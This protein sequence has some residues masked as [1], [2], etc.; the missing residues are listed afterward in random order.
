MPVAGIGRLLEC[1]YSAESSFCENAESAASNTW[2]NKIAFDGYTLSTN[3]D[4]IRDGSHVSRMNDEG[5]SHIGPRDAA[6]EFTTPLPGHFT[7]T[8]G[9]LTATWVHDLL[10]DA[11]GGGKTDFA[12][13]TVSA[14]SSASSIT[15]T[16]TSNLA[17]GHI[18][19]IGA[20]G[21]GRCDGQ[22]GVVNSAA[23][24][25][26][27]L[28]A[29]PGTPNAADVIYGT[30]LVYP[31]ESTAHTLGTKRFMAGWTSSPTTGQQYHLMGGQL[32]TL[33]FSFP[34][35]TPSPPTVSFGYRFAYYQR[36]A[37]TI[38]HTSL[39]R[40]NNYYAPCMGGS[41]FLADF[42]TATRT[43]VQPASIDLTIDL[44]LEPI[45]GPGGAGIYQQIIGWV[46]TASKPTVTMVLP[47]ATTYE[48]LFDTANA[49]Y[50]YKH[51]LFTGNV[52]DGR[53]VGFY[54]P[55]CMLVGN[56]PSQPTL[57]NGQTYVTVQFVGVESTTTTTELTRS[58][59]RL[60][61][62]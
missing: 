2:T 62:G 1:L 61:M 32:A 51:L 24:P 31:D 8:A 49:S 47:W 45:Y 14:A 36:A 7:T 29:F 60:F 57:I 37:M 13:T 3:Q 23:S 9:S 20:K 40:E 56:R 53:S 59:W 41:V 33:Q 21:D 16:S 28:T 6:L 4:R 17:T 10:S 50:T 22:A 42:A 38:P 34:L 27:H 48:T 52:I 55:R 30:Q 15:Y 58:A 54:L 44:G 25:V 18:V 26:T 46:R 35:Q 43:T 12:G 5:L 39:T 19:R 11:L